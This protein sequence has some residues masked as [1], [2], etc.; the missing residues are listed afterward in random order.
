ME[1]SAFAMS[2]AAMR[3]P[4]LT[5]SILGLKCACVCVYVCV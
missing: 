1:V 3:Y 2:H 4:W 5:Q